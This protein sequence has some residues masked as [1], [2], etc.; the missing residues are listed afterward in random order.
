MLL[1]MSEELFL[2]KTYRRKHHDNVF[3]KS[4]FVQRSCGN[5]CGSRNKP[6][7]LGVNYKLIIK[8]A[9]KIKVVKLIS[10]K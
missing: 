9:K 7:K 3:I 6:R 1:H 2:V 4:I 8:T 10:R 5:N